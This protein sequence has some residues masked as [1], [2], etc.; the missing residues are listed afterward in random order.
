MAVALTPLTSTQCAS[1]D[2]LFALGVQVFAHAPTLHTFL[3]SDDVFR[4]FVRRAPYEFAR[5]IP[6][7]R[8]LL[9]EYDKHAPGL[10]RVAFTLECEWDKGVDGWWYHIEGED[11]IVW[12]R[13]AALQDAHAVHEYDKHD[14]T[15]L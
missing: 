14:G 6:L 9:A 15:P 8:S 1:Q 13:R 12:R 5:D 7:Q 3:L 10:R 4:F 11:P 2:D